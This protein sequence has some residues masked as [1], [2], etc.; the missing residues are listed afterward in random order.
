MKTLKRLVEEIVKNKPEVPMFKHNSREGDQFGE[1]EID[2]YS[3]GSNEDDEQWPYH[4]FSDETGEENDDLGII[5]LNKTPVKEQKPVPA[6]PKPEKEPETIPTPAPSKPEK[7]PR[8]SPFT[9]PKPERDPQ[10]KAKKR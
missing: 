1:E 9:P 6:P 3:I 4:E 7:E 2:R 10:P 8:W 5:D